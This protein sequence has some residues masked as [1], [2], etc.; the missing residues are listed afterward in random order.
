MNNLIELEINLASTKKP[1]LAKTLKLMHSNIY[2]F[3]VL[4]S[5]CYHSVAVGPQVALISIHTLNTL[6]YSV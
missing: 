3:K 2:S 6:L 1:L 4:V 5:T